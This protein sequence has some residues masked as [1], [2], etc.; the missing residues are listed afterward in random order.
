ME[1]V[2]GCIKHFTNARVRCRI[3]SPVPFFPESFV[4]GNGWSLHS[5]RYPN[6]VE[7]A[8]TVKKEGDRP[9]RINQSEISSLERFT[10]RL[11][12]LGT[13]EERMKKEKRA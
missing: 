13:G 9:A 2:G 3:E 6:V 12:R 8:W 5:I 10:F 1:R 7:G 4:P 11:C